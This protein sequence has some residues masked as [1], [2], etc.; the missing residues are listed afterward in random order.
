LLNVNAI[1]VQSQLSLVELSTM[2]NARRIGRHVT[3]DKFTVR[4]I[5]VLHIITTDARDA[6][7]IKESASQTGGEGSIRRIILTESA[8]AYYGTVRL[9]L[10]GFGLVT[11]S[12]RLYFYAFAYDRRI[13]LLQV[14]GRKVNSLASFVQ[15][16]KLCM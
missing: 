14:I 11:C 5:I 15:T 6:T 13:L 9:L 2:L 16:A 12:S 7:N 1:R 10:T 3:V 8:V 4:C